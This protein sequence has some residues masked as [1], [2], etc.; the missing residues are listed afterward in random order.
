MTEMIYQL[1]FKTLLYRY[2]FFEWLFKD[3]SVGNMFEKSAAWRHNKENA[4]WLPTYMKR[5]TVMGLILFSLGIVFEST[6]KMPVASAFFYV[7]SILAF[8]VNAVIGV[9]WAGFKLM[10]SPF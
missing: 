1:P 7:P 4:K 5:W 3:C 8:P 9:A 10:N 6:L 2:M